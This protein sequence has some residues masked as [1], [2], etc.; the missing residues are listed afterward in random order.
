MTVY[1]PWNACW[2]IVEISVGLVTLATT[3]T[4]WNFQYFYTMPI[5]TAQH[6]HFTWVQGMN[7]SK[8]RSYTRCLLIP[9][10]VAYYEN[11]SGTVCHS[12]FITLSGNALRTLTSIYNK[13]KKTK[14]CVLGHAKNF[15]SMSFPS[16]SLVVGHLPLL[17]YYHIYF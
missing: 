9:P 8:G 14:I 4:I 7:I 2:D 10:Y 12:W 5:Y 1:K 17:N 13:C 6:R 11:N 16:S 15:S 3:E